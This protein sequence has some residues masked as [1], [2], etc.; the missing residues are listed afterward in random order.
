M[1]RSVGVTKGEAL[2]CQSCGFENVDRSVYCGQCRAALARPCRVCG[3][4]VPLDASACPA[5]GASLAMAA[6]HS[7]PSAGPPPQPAP[8]YRASPPGRATPAGAATR[9]RPRSAPSEGTRFTGVVRDLRHRDRDDAGT[10]MTVLDFRIERHDASGNRLAPV[11][12]QMRGQSFSGAVNNGDE[13]RVNRGKWR[14][15]TLRV[16]DLD[17]LSTGAE[18][19]TKG[20]G[21]FGW[22]LGVVVSLF[23]LA[24]GGFVVF[25]IVYVG[26]LGNEPPFG[27]PYGP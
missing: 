1:Q 11:P 2:R 6:P 14:D 17:N 13:I 8:V 3:E 21:A 22:I 7:A 18:V 26:I 9:G 5:C 20:S 24:V 27:G 19:R 4:P 15:G 25:M 16:K 12:V 10:E 23:I